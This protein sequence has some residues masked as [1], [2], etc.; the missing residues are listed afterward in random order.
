MRKATQTNVTATTALHTRK[1]RS[2][3]V[4][5][6]SGRSHLKR[7]SMKAT[8]S[9]PT[10]SIA[11]DCAHAGHSTWRCYHGGWQAPRAIASMPSGHEQHGSVDAV[12][13]HCPRT[14]ARLKGR[15]RLRSP[16][17]RAPPRS[18]FRLPVSRSVRCAADRQRGGPVGHRRTS[19]GA[20][21]ERRL[22]PRATQPFSSGSHMLAMSRKLGVS[23]SDVIDS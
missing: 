18:S 17:T 6:S 23:L 22:A 13:C 14:S 19:G 1:M 2:Q 10:P 21:D 11:I 12:G 20:P 4:R 15:T 16:A 5:R 8:K 9:A 7:T 3:R